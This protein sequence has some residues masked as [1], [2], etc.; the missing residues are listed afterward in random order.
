M[1]EG[2]EVE[3]G[4]PGVGE[5]RREAEEGVGLVVEVDRAASAAGQEGRVVSVVEGEAFR[6]GEEEGIDLDLLT[7]RSIF[8]G[9]KARVVLTT[10]G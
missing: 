3:V 10:V 2:E 9:C 8:R 4:L 6:E 1:T 7:L 5:V